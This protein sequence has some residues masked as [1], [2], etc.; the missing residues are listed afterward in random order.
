MKLGIYILCH[1]KKW[2]LKSTLL[3][4]F[5]QKNLKNYELNFILILGDGS[6]KRKFYNE[7]LSKFDDDLLG[8]IKKVKIRYNIIKLKNDDGLDSGAWLKIIKKKSYQ[9]YLYSIFLMEG[10][11]FTNR[12]VLNDTLYFMKKN[13]SEVVST[14]HEKRFFTHK[15]LNQ[16]YLRGKPN[17]KN[18]YLQKQL[19]KIRNPII[20]KILKINP[21]D[22]NDNLNFKINDNE[23]FRTEYHTPKYRL[24][25]YQKIKIFIKSLIKIKNFKI[26]FNRKILIYNHFGPL[27]LSMDNISQKIKKVGLTTFHKEK[28][29]L[30]FGCSCQHIFTR[31][32]LDNL[33][34]FL[35]QNGYFRLQKEDF[36]GHAFECVWGYLPIA[37]KK[38]KWFFD[39]IMRPRKN[40]LTLQRE[41]NNQDLIDFINLYYS[42]CVNVEKINNRDFKVTSNKEVQLDRFMDLN[43]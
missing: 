5:L 30:F 22:F 28:S 38:E 34:S 15:F 9:K 10:S 43:S 11:I 8:V 23:V 36:F 21:R 13:K 33:R 37:L 31:K 41:D 4:L 27:Y 12:N 1:H 25:L 39:G 19:N 16:M 24:S 14:G 40:I 29:P 26:L 17:K 7:Q 35:N 6:K 32:F 20:K 42:S 3:S 2:L 18:Q